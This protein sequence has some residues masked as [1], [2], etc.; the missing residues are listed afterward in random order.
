[1][2][3]VAAGVALCGSDLTDSWIAQHVERTGW[4][5]ACVVHASKTPS[6]VW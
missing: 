6:S 1:M 2:R 5:V 3:D 4:V